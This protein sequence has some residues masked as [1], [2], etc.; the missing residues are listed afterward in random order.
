MKV[1]SSELEVEYIISR[2]Q[3]SSKSNDWDNFLVASGK[4]NGNSGNKSIKTVYLNEVHFS[5]INNNLL[6]FQYKT[7]G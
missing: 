6:S 4:W 3:D 7:V 1:F 5:H 2:D